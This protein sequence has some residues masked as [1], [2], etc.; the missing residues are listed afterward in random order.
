MLARVL[1]QA[2]KQLGIHPGDPGWR[3]QQSFAV[4]VFAHRRQNLADR[5]LDP[6][7]IDRPAS[8]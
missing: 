8:R 1:M 7:Q 4:G 5:P 6:G 3:F 2:A